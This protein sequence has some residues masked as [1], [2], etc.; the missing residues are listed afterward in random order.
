MNRLFACLALSA[1][2]AAGCSDLPKLHTDDAVKAKA[3]A[4]EA[5]PP[6]PKPAPTNRTVTADQV[7]DGNARAMAEALREELDK[8]EPRTPAPTTPA[9][10]R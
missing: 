7:N 2:V 6:A 9:P 1:F 8:D 4:K 5:E 10:K 3:P